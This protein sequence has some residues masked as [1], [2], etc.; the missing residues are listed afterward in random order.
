VGFECPRKKLE[1]FDD[2]W[3]GTYGKRK[4]ANRTAAIL[5][6][7]QLLMDNLEKEKRQRETSP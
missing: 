1:A 4:Y 6:G 2:A 7:M 5:A 3:K